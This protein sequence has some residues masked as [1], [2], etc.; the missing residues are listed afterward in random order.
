M[1]KIEELIDQAL[2][3][4]PSFKLRGDFKDRVLKAIRRKE[5]M[6]QRKLYVLMALGIVVM[7]GFGLAILAYFQNLEALSALKNIVPMAVMIGGVVALVQYLDN[8]LV[9]KKMFNQQLS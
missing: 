5:K 3:N 7:F 9:K 4:E 6:S 2:Q 8:K 1:K